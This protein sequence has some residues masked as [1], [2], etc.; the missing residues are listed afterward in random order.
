MAEQVLHIGSYSGRVSILG[1]LHLLAVHHRRLRMIFHVEFQHV[2]VVDRVD[3]GVGVQGFGVLPLFVQLTAEDV[4]CGHHVALHIGGGVHAEN[5]RA[6]ESEHNVVLE[7]VLDAPLHL[8]KLRAVAL[9]ED[10]YEIP[11]QHFSLYLVFLQEARHLL[12]GGDDDVRGVTWLE[13]T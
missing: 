13:L 12:Y 6:C 2:L 11:V 8:A 5:R 4:G 10:E 9:V 1:V 3:D 7:A